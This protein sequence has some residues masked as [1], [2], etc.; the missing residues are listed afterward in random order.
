MS[1]DS[2]TLL[3]DIIPEAIP[4]QKCH[5]NKGPLWTLLKIWVFEMWDMGV[6]MYIYIGKPVHL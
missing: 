6:G 2:M 4:S 1:G 3:Q 5:M